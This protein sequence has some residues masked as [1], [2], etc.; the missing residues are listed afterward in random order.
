MRRGEKV[1]LPADMYDAL[2]LS[3]HA[4]G[5][6]GAPRV[7]DV[8]DATPCCFYGHAS[9]VTNNGPEDSINNVISDKLCKHIAGPGYYSDEAVY[10][11][12]V[13]LGKGS[14]CGDRVTFKQWAKEMNIVRGA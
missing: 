5:G 13:R 12:N 14:R 4:H 7:F 11:I 6:I 3:A 2:E 10:A 1:V 8:G 9:F